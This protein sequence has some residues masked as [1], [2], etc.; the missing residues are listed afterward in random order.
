MPITIQQLS[1]GQLAKMIDEN[2]KH[3]TPEEQL[4]YWG[5]IYEKYREVMDRPEIKA[6]GFKKDV[7]LYMRE[8]DGY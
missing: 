3:S 5:M 6:E 1:H 2:L 8:R 7:E 4:K